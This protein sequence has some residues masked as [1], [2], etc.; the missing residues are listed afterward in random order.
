MP[1]KLVK[2][3]EMD[4]QSDTRSVYKLDPN[5]SDVGGSIDTIAA[6]HR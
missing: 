3:S 1:G 4:M 5:S 2:I 6:R